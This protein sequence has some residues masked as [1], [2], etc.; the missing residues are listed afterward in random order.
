M[1]GRGLRPAPGKSDCVVLD[2]RGNAGRHSLVSPMDILDE[3][4]G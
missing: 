4:F 3:L 1:I 2:F